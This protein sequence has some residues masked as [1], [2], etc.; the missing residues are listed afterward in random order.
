ML[1]K[2]RS[3]FHDTFSLF[4]FTWY[5]CPKCGYESSRGG[6]ICR[7]GA[8]CQF[9]EGKWIMVGAEEASQNV[10]VSN[11]LSFLFLVLF[12]GGLIA[13]ALSRPW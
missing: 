10:I 12:L 1:S 2:L 8:D 11:F 4:P 7:E 5:R 9:K 6:R 3:F 13:R